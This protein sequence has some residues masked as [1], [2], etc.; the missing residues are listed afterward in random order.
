MWEFE[1]GDRVGSGLDRWM[2]TSRKS[3]SLEK[4]ATIGRVNSTSIRL[5]TRRATMLV[6]PP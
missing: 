5:L 2:L 6:S 4:W 1:R 3:A